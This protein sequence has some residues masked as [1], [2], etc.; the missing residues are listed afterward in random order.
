MNRSIGMTMER[1]HTRLTLIEDVL[2]ILA[3][4]SLWPT[5]LG[6][7]GIIF[8]V[9]PFLALGVLLVILTRRIGRIKSSHE[10][11]D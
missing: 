5:I 4:F 10:K 8:K 9:I 1:R 3:I 6:W 11:S 7:Q 2:I